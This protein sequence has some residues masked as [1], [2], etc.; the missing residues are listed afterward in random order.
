MTSRDVSAG[1]AA[2]LDD[3]TIGIEPAPPELRRLGAFDIAVLWGDLAVGILVLAA[4]ALLVAPSASGGLGM[5]LGRAL[6]AIAIGSVAG[7]LLLALV[8]VAGHARAEPTMALLRPVLGRRGSY[9]ASVVNA[10]QLVGWTAFEF[11]AMAHFASR[12]SRSVFGFG[13][14]DLWLAVVAVVCTALA[15]WGPIRF[16]RLWLERGGLWVVVV[17]CGALTV[18]LLTRHGLGGDLSTGAHGASLPVGVDLVIAQPVSW[19]AAVADYNRFARRRRSQFVGTW[20]GYTIGNAW[21]YALGA[22]LVLTA[23]LSDASPDGVAASILGLSATAALG[24]V[25]L[26]ALLGGE[27]HEGFADIYSTAISV[28]N[29][30][31]GLPQRLVVVAVGVVGAGLAAVATLGSYEA[32]LILLGSVFVPLFVVML[33]EWVNGALRPGQPE[34][35]TRPP[36]IAAWLAGIALY[37]WIVAPGTLPAWWTRIV[38][39][40]LPGAGTHTGWGASLPCFAATGLAVL[41]IGW[42]SRRLRPPRP[43]PTPLWD[44]RVA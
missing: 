18:Y 22:L 13:A 30:L 16:V 27:T 24:L 21:F 28:R 39:H 4:G 9:L 6:I 1:T 44:R 41:T 33:A 42:V 25:V 14:Y 34:P 23:H 40:V 32:F 7:S 31:P 35:A 17:T 15:C 26:V 36:M 20:A 3:A 12:A 43:P 11:W 37:Q 19:L 10:T 29:I 38:R 5:N 2:T 8:G